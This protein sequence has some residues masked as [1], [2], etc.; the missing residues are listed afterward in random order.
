MIISKNTLFCF[1]DLGN[2][3]FAYRA[4]LNYMEISKSV[5]YNFNEME[6]KLLNVLRKCRAIR[7]RVYVSTFLYQQ[8]IS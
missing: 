2:F 4:N 5:K 6:K 7:A 1:G 8:E 3:R